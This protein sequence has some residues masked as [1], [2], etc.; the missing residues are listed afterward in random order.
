LYFLFSLKRWLLRILPWPFPPA[1]PPCRF[2]VFPLMHSPPHCSRAG[3][4]T[5]SAFSFALITPRFFCFFRP[6]SSTFLLNIAFFFSVYLGTLTDRCLFLRPVFF[7]SIDR[8][9]EIK[10]GVL[11]SQMTPVGPNLTSCLTVPN[12]IPWSVSY[13][14]LTARTLTDVFRLSP[15]PL[16]LP[17]LCVPLQVFSLFLLFF[18]R[19]EHPSATF[20]LFPPLRFSVPLESGPGKVLFRSCLF[21]EIC[22]FIV[23]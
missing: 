10:F 3:H 13:N 21:T 6:K 12:T 23:L 19:S 15:F 2:P 20:C 16:C 1:T 22:R 11:S 17:P 4:P 8:F 9:D 5:V 18:W 14:V 7:S